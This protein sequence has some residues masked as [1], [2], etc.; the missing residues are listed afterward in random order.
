MTRQEPRIPVSAPAS[1][2][3]HGGTSVGGSVG[4]VVPPTKPSWCSWRETAWLDIQW[5]TATESGT[6]YEMESLWESLVK[7][8]QGFQSLNLV[9]PAILQRSSSATQEPIE[10]D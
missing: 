4:S 1:C 2:S 9:E 8:L 6:C 3:A 10:N 5:E 7:K